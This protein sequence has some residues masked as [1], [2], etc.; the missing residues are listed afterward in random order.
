MKYTYN[1]N[2]E[3][4]FI[5]ERDKLAWLKT[6]YSHCWTLVRDADGFMLVSFLDDMFR[7]VWNYKHLTS[8]FEVYKEIRSIWLP[9]GIAEEKQL[10]L[11]TIK[12][13][14][15]RKSGN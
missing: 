2:M 13:Y 9:N 10:C 4:D 1:K 3:F 12:D 8:A 5:S 6:R 14:T 15:E 11:E 7:A